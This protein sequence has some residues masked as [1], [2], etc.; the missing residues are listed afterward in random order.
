MSPYLSHFAAITCGLSVAA[1]APGS[2]RDV[3]AAGDGLT[4]DES[5]WMWSRAQATVLMSCHADGGRLQ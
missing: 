4:C 3:H 1:L 5:A 2:L